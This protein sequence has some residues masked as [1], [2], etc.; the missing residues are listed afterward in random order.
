MKLLALGEYAW[1]SINGF[2]TNQ[3]RYHTSLVLWKW[4]EWFDGSFE[5]LII[6][7]LLRKVDTLIGL[8]KVISQAECMSSAWLI[9]C[10]KLGI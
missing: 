9:L 5:P 2:E 7:Q 6:S 3:T 4:A 10:V 8:R 1:L